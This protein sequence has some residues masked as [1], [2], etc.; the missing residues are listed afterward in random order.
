MPPCV[1]AT[2][3]PQ[4]SESAGGSSGLPS[5]HEAQ[6]KQGEFGHLQTQADAEKTLRMLLALFPEVGHGDTGPSSFTWI[7]PDEVPGQQHSRSLLSFSQSLVHEEHLTKVL[8]DQ[9]T[10]DF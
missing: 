9:L 10:G 3:V 4:G 5:A 2:L 7:R 1:Q 6:A 8:Q